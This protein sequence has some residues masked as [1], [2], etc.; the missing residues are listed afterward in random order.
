MDQF[1]RIKKIEKSDLQCLCF[2]EMGKVESF[3]EDPNT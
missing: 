2:I 1:K 3:L